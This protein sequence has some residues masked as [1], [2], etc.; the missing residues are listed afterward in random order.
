MTT[1]RRLF[2]ISLTV[3]LACSSA[4]APA[5]TVTALVTPEGIQATNRTSRAVFYLPVER[6]ALA[7]LYY[8]RSTD[9]ANQKH[10]GPGA[11]TVVP[12][13]DVVAF[14]SGK[15]HYVLVWW[16]S[17]IVGQGLEGQVQLFRP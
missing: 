15:H 12:W 10:I 8:T 13:S 16:Q 1:T 7:A 5:D 17:S 4:T 14:D 2:L 9:A 3:G 6:D 11:S